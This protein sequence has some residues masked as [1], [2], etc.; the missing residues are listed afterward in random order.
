M[1]RA[2]SNPDILSRF[3]E[4]IAEGERL[5]LEAKKTEGKEIPSAPITQWITSSLNLLDKLS[6]STNRFVQEFERYGRVENGLLNIG[7][8]LGVLCAACEEY[9]LGFAVDY[10]LAVASTVFGDLLTEAQYLEEKGYYRAAVVLSGAA[11]EESLRSRTRATTSLELSSHESIT[12]LIHKLKAPTVGVLDELEASRL[13]VWAKMRNQA[14][15]GKEITFKHEEVTRMRIE[16]GRTIE[17]IL[18][19]R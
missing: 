13:E 14:A 7:L 16:I 19:H 3:D 9:K 11:L 1:T 18:G 6:V 2:F 10:H 4:L 17:S 12:T 8:P 15:H 5:R